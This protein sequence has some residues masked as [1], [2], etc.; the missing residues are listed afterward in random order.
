MVAV[1]IN[2]ICL[3]IVSIS[4][5]NYKAGFVLSLCAK[6]I[7]PSFVSV[8]VAGGA[9]NVHDL[10]LLGLL[11][12]FVIN[13]IYRNIEFPILIKRLFLIQ[14]IATFLLI[15]FSSQVVPL[16]YQ[17]KALIKGTIFQ[18]ILYL[19]L[20][21]YAIFQADYKVFL[22]IILVVS[23]IVGIYGLLS[24]F[25]GTNLYVNCLS[26]LYSGHES[27]FSVFSEE[28]R[29]GLS[30]RVSGTFSHPLTWG[31]FWDIILA[32]YFIFK[33]DIN[34]YIRYGVLLLALVNIVLSGSRSAIVAAIVAGLFYLFSLTPKKQV[35]TL[36]SL[37]IITFLFCIYGMGNRSF[38]NIYNYILSAIYF[39]DSEKSANIGIVGSS[40]SMR[41]EQ[42]LEAWDIAEKHIG[43]YGYQYQFYI[44]DTIYENTTLRGL[45]SVLLK[46]L[47]EQGFLGIVIFVFLYFLFALYVT[48][49]S[50]SGKGRFI[51]WGYF[52][53]Y[54]CSITM[55]GVQGTWIFFFVFPFLYVRKNIEKDR[56]QKEIFY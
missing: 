44:L 50:S 26:V 27:L 30:G 55:T 51:V 4:L 22:H 6:I 54:L 15:L 56:L 31:Q 10:L 14:I 28:E 8:R 49:Y 40:T 12:S 47:V 43:G 42:F 11:A 29:G 35:K 39:W 9:I 45:E 21:I 52:V 33:K 25:I 7:F 32:L 46:T 38:N 13:K 19:V 34:S 3:I 48:K 36:F 23:I 1:V 16:E 41:E 2:I 20:G 37:V 17:I 5:W 18:E 24:Y 53:S